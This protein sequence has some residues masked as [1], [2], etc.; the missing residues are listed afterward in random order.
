MQVRGY[1]HSYNVEKDVCSMALAVRC[2]NALCSR[3]GCTIVG[4]SNVS[5]LSTRVCAL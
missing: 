3:A 2:W 4:P 1:A 5:P